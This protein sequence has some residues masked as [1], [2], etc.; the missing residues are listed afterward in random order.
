MTWTFEHI[1][2]IFIKT[3]ESYHQRFSE[4]GDWFFDADSNELTIFVT[5]MSD[6]R[7]ELAVA[8]HELYEAVAFLADGGDQTDVDFFD[9]K[10][11]TNKEMDG[12]AGDQ[13]D[14]PYH[15]Q[16]WQATKVEKEVVAQ[17]ELEWHQ[18]ESN[19]DEA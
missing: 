11:Y 9:K 5:K 2:R 17:L 1:P 19:C 7:S 3:V 4:C 16:H 6:W 15:K 13:G 14:A 8:I 10:F 18:H 12:Q